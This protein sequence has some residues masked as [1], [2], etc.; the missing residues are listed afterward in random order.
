MT[1]REAVVQV[2]VDSDCIDENGEPMERRRG[3]GRARGW[4]SDRAGVRSALLPRAPP[5][6]KES[7]TTYSARPQPKITA[8]TFNVL[9]C[10]PEQAKAD[11]ERRH[12]DVAGPQAH[13]GLEDALVALDLTVGDLQAQ[14]SVSKGSVEER[15]AARATTYP[16]IEVA[17]DEL[18]DD[19]GDDRR[20]VHRGRHVRRE[21]VADRGRATD[22][23]GEVRAS[24]ATAAA[25]A[26]VYERAAGRTEDGLRDVDADAEAESHAD[27]CR[28]E[29]EGQSSEGCEREQEGETHRGASGACAGARGSRRL[30]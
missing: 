3:K 11:N 26:R 7:K 25:V 17:A 5:S 15:K 1:G 23:E 2:G 6:T 4:V 20:S 10:R 19:D 29:E 21:A 18:A 24:A 28:S 16:V 12:A 8:A 27:V 13:L 30:T 22:C 14:S 9:E